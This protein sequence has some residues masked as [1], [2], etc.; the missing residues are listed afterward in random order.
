MKESVAYFK[1]EFNSKNIVRIFSAIS[2][3]FFLIFMVDCA[4]SGAGRLIEF[5]PI[6]FRM[7]VMLL[8]LFFSLPAFFLK[9]KEYIKNPMVIGLLIFFLILAISAFRGYFAGNRMDVLLSDIKGFMY[10]AILPCALVVIDTKDKILF[11]IKCLVVSS[12]ILA[13]T[14]IALNFMV[15]YAENFFLTIY[16]PIREVMFGSIH[17][18]S[19]TI[20][21][22]FPRSIPY[23][24]VGVVFSFY[25]WLTQ[26]KKK[27][28][29]LYAL[30]ISVGIWAM[31]LSF[32]RSIF[33]AV[34]V[35]VLGFLILFLVYNRDKIK[36]TMQALIISLAG[37]VLV[38]VIVCIPVGT[39][40]IEFAVSRTVA[41][42]E[43][44][45]D[46]GDMGDRKSDG[47]S[48]EDYISDTI[49]SDS[50]RN[51]TTRQLIEM[52]KK[53]PIVGN[54]LGSAIEQRKNGLVEN[55]YLD[56]INKIGVI[57]L[58]AYYL[59]IFWMVYKLFH[60]IIKKKPYTNIL[61]A[62]SAG[63]LVFISATYFNPYMNASLGIS[64]YA[65]A[66]AAFTVALRQ[67]K[68][69]QLTR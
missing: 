69:Q 15:I 33:G 23:I 47:S 67:D 39:N 43:D 36:F 59:P 54:G 4:F 26:G 57:G 46:T 10:F 28:N 50:Y 7:L 49:T 52:I 1:E 32:T 66:I 25:L 5:G 65:F 8:A 24:A 51:E 16:K 40:Y 11:T 63:F 35:S 21:R 37:F 6:S 45:S 55:T 53:N 41:T 42:L 29:Y 61:I 17:K 22:I 19:D 14:V 56:L 3:L 60:S 13:I 31:I 62:V 68:K 9:I 2:Y 27:L 12:F 44:V 20:F 34:F 30:I 58:L 64:Y 18:V 48:A 38:A